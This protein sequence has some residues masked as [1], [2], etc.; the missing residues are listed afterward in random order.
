MVETAWTPET[1]IQ[2]SKN[3]IPPAGSTGEGSRGMNNPEDGES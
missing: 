2:L 1:L 3:G